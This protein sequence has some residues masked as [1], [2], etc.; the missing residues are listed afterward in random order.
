MFSFI[1]KAYQTL[2][3]AEKKFLFWA[4]LVILFFSSVNWIF[5]LI[6][7][8]DNLYH[9][10]VNTI[11]GSDKPVYISQIEQARQGHILF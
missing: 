11:A 7:E 8:N 1:K 5:A 3:T 10:S 4:I 2:T 9:T 6:V